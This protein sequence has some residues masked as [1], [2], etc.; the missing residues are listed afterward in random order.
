MTPTV[1][2]EELIKWLRANYSVQEDKM[3][4]GK[5][6]YKLTIEMPLRTGTSVAKTITSHHS[7]STY[8]RMALYIE[9]SPIWTAWVSEKIA[10]GLKTLIEQLKENSMLMIHRPDGSVVGPAP[11]SVYECFAQYILIKPGTYE[12]YRS[13]LQNQHHETKGSDNQGSADGLPA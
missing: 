10:P 12:E 7:D 3:A 5:K 6:C 1:S 9:N 11:D 2:R 13:W 4:T 8:S